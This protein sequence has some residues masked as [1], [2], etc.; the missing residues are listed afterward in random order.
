VNRND[1]TFSIFIWILVLKVYEVMDNR[2]HEN[3]WSF[4]NYVRLS[5]QEYWD[6]QVM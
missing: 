1:F 6:G 5:N 4:C 3:T 2:N